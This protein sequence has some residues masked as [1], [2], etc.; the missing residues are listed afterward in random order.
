MNIHELNAL[1]LDE[2]SEALLGCCGTPWWAQQMAHARPFA[3]AAELHDTADAVFE[4]MDDGHWLQAFAAHPRLGDLESLRMKFVGNDRW[5]ARE[6]AGITDADEDLLRNLAE[7]NV[8]YEQRFGH[9][10]ILCA[11]GV[12]AGDMLA[13]LTRRMRNDPQREAQ[14]A[15]AEQRKITHLRLDKLLGVDA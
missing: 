9:I 8:R 5:S 1:P 12:T 7:A 6:Q 2:A 14:V 10:F 15:G 11:T 13:A 4:V 3:S